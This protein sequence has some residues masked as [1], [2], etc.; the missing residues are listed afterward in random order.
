VGSFLPWATVD[1]MFSIYSSS[2][3]EMGYGVATFIAGVALSLIGLAAA[4]SGGVS[5]FRRIGTVSAIVTL[6][7]VLGV[8]AIVQF[9]I[10]EDD[11]TEFLRSSFGHLLIGIYV[12][13]LGAVIAAIGVFRLKSRPS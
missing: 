2:G 5:R 12:A 11:S 9:H 3:I 1:F 10:G 13:A 4:R 7:V 6:V 8:S